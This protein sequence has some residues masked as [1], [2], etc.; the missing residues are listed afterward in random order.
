MRYT[1]IAF[2][3]VRQHD[4]LRSRLSRAV[5]AFLFD[6]LN[7]ALAHQTAHLDEIRRS[8]A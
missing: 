1:P 2:Q 5:P 6:R 7:I 8:L 4:S 3:L